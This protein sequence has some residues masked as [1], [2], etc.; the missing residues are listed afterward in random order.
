MH[1]LQLL[2]YIQQVK[3]Y[4]WYSSVFMNNKNNTKCTFIANVSQ[5]SVQAF[6]IFNFKKIKR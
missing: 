4:Y 6:D 2:K 5:K 3:M 1:T